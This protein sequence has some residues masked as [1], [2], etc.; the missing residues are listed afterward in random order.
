MFF[1]AEQMAIIGKEHDWKKLTPYF[2]KCARIFNPVLSMMGTFNLDAPPVE[3]TQKERRQQ[4]QNE[5]VSVVRSYETIYS[6]FSLHRLSKYSHI[7]KNPK[8]QR[9]QNVFSSSMSS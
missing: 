1:H 5:L 6:I 7:L 4:L 8:R 9:E 2:L 3:T